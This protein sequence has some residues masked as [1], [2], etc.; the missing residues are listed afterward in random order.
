MTFMRSSERFWT[1]HKYVS[2][3]GIQRGFYRCA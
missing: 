3:N 1:W 2:H